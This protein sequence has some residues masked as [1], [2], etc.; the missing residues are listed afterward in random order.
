MELKDFFLGQ[1]E[2]EA[3]ASRKAIDRVPEGR[4]DWKPHEKSMDLGHLASLS[5]TM[6]GWV[7]LMIER[8][9]LALD[10]PANENLKTKPASSRAELARSLDESVAKSQKALKETSEEHLRKHWKLVL[11]GKAVIDQPRYEVIAD[12]FCHLGHHRGQL[13]V[14]LRL[15][16]ASVPAIYGPSADEFETPA[17][18]NQPVPELVI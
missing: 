2:R 1:L 6:P 3:D 11:G 15:L 5:A 10:D 14:Y 9:E 4:G 7:A 16:G 8:D 12:T 17:A 13:T 18:R